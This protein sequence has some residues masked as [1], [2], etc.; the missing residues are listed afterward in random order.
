MNL[1]LY[2]KDLLLNNEKGIY[3]VASFDKPSII[4]IKN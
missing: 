2:G 4:T 3:A 1:Y